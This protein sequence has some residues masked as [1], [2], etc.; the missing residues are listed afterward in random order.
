MSRG[1][2]GKDG[3]EGEAGG[4]E[5]KTN[6]LRGTILL[7]RLVFPATRLPGRRGVA[8]GVRNVGPVQAREVGVAAVPA[9]LALGARGHGGAGAD[10][11]GAPGL[12]GGGGGGGAE[13]EVGEEAHWRRWL[14]FRPCVAGAE[15]EASSLP[16]LG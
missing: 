3:G 6:P 11:G 2:Y 15:A 7:Q 14:V 13:G 5:A 10:V 1:G 8:D 9:A 16:V 12:G 4:G